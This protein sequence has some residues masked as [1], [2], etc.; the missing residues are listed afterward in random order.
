MHLFKRFSVK[1]SQLAR[2]ALAVGCVNAVAKAD[3][4]AP[5]FHRWAPT[6][7]MGWNSWDAF[8]TTLNEA[9]AKEHADIMSSQLLAHGWQYL[10]VDIQWYEPNATGFDYHPGASLTMDKFGRLVPAP[11]KFPSATNDAGFKPLA[12]Y[13]H[14]KGLKF[15]IHLMRGIP[16]QAVEKNLP[17]KDTV[18]T[19]AEIADKVNV[20]EW[21]KDMYGV[22]MKKPGAQAYYDSVFALIASWGVDFVKVD[23]LSRPYI[24]NEPEIEAIRN[25]IDKTGRAM[26]LSLSPG[27]TDINAAKHVVAHANMWRISD[28]FWDHW[29]LLEGQFKRLNDWSKWREIGAWPDADMI[30][31]G[32]IELGRKTWF[33]PTEQTT[34]MT[35]W[36]I[37]RSP[38]ILGADLTK[39]DDWT[40]SL[41]V[42]DEVLAVNQHSAGNHQLFRDAEGR[43]AWI[44]D[45]PEHKG[46]YLALFNTR[47][48]WVLT[49]SK[50]LW[51]S[52][53]LVQ[54]EA[55]TSVDFR[56]VTKG[57]QTVVLT[58]DDH[59]SP[60]F[61]WPSLF[62]GLHWVFA[63][64]HEVA[65]DREY[66]SHG[67]R[68]NGLAVPAGAV[69]LRGTAWLDDAAKND[70]KGERIVFE[71]YGFTANDLAKAG[72]AVP[73]DVSDLGLG[74][75]V[76]LRDLWRH[77]DLGIAEKTFAPEIEWHG[78]RL[79]RVSGE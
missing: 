44:A 74:K 16:R 54:G 49:E 46:K 63:D 19:A 12:D 57:L 65:A 59:E 28:D 35:L 4:T 31:I 37:A 3:S 1:I 61:W 17:I 47:D 30:P 60:R 68:V 72:Q 50:R 75:K 6:P 53:P 70:G 48:P 15:G 8:A 21:N 25:A 69:A 51:R 71:A 10:V 2:L 55:K 5:D 78:A 42:N 43:I 41:I 45:A 36:S 76:R 33:T 52:A 14:S 34:L 39:L 26:V 73:V 7:P 38:L 32:T 62:R 27:E 56:V 24:R 77:E 13:V 58:A 11:N 22:D 18:Y 23:D 29:S 79:Y 67:E 66:G 20:C 64:G 9:K 40:R